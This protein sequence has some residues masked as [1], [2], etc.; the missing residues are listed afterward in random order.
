MFNLLSGALA[1]FRCLRLTS[2]Q[3]RRDTF[4]A[5]PT[6]LV[7][8]VL[9]FHVKLYRTRRWVQFS[10]FSHTTSNIP[11]RKSRREIYYKDFEENLFATCSFGV[12]LS[13]DFLS[14]EFPSECFLPFVFSTT[15][16]SL[17]VLFEAWESFSFFTSGD[18]S[19]SLKKIYFQIS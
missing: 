14:S 9:I 15:S 13:W 16:P 4:S 5:S 3:C 11:S 8:L 7:R 1:M 18:F 12:W 19:S 10:S 2:L 6:I 17:F